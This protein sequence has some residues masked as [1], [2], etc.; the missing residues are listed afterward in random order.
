LVNSL[1]YRQAETTWAP[2]EA[3]R[4]VFLTIDLAVQKAAEQA[5]RSAPVPYSGPPRGAVV[6]MDPRT[7]D[8]IAMASNPTYDPNDLVQHLSP[9]KAA[10]LNDPI[11]RPQINRAMQ[12]NYAPGSIFKIVVGLAGLEAGTLDPDEVYHSLGRYELGRGH[13]RIDDPAGPG[14][15]KFLRALIKSSNS[16]FIHEGM[17]LGVDRI[18]EMGKRFHLGE[19]TGLLPFQ[20]TAGI[21]PT[22]EWRK[23]KLGGAWFDGNTM[24]ISFGQG[25]LAVTP[26]QVAVMIS[27]IANGGTVFWPRLVA[28]TESQDPFAD[29]PPVLVP[30][31]KIR[32]YLNVSKHN[33]DI[34][35]EAMAA[36]V[37]HAE[38]TGKKAYVP[39]LRICAKTG[40][41]QIMTGRKV[42]GHTVWFASFAPYENPRYVV[43][44]MF[45]TEQGGSGG[46]TCA[47]VAH[48]IYLALQKRDQPPRP[49]KPETLA[50]R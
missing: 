5:L 18:V 43:V 40:T 45:E 16:Y 22:R 13:R 29:D 20:E 27:A 50:T 21:L 34:L 14:E 39:G 28:R 19:R 2:S 35:H 17:K 15:F 10:Y 12:E 26:L 47:P 3:G 33:L 49:A 37:E 38:G 24:N 23:E 9:E 8:L 48:Q 30:A 6:V 7:G 44:V 1:G 41:A 32:S 4:N 25:E 31:G 11:L 36:D 42:V 46:D